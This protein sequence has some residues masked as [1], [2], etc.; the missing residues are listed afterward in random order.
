MTGSI[1]DLGSS[2]ERYR[3][4]TISLVD[5]DGQWVT[6]GGGS[7]SRTGQDELSWS[8]GGTYARPFSYYVD[9]PVEGTITESGRQGGSHTFSTQAILNPDDTLE[10]TGGGVSEEHEEEEFTWSGGGSFSGSDTVTT[11]LS[12]GGQST[13]ITTTGRSFSENGSFGNWSSTA[14]AWV[15]DPNGWRAAEELTGEGGHDEGGYTSSFE[16][17]RDTVV[18]AN[19]QTTTDWDHVLD[20]VSESFDYGYERT[21]TVSTAA[22]GT[23][24]VSG[25]AAGGG[26][27][28]GTGSHVEWNRDGRMEPGREPFCSSRRSLPGLVIR[29]A[30]TTPAACPTASCRCRLRTPRPAPA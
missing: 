19:G 21:L 29:G 26:W 22:D 8:G 18:T 9:M 27:A 17:T 15:R 24:T 28:I 7:T 25:A 6:T 1:T 3:F 2:S 12:G 20:A 16:Q 11:P 4:S 5:E 14:I 23:E 30:A 10:V 13:T